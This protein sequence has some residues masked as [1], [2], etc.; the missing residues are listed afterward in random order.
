MLCSMAER[1]KFKK[2]NVL[3]KTNSEGQTCMLVCSENL[4][5]ALN[6]QA[7][8]PRLQLFTEPCIRWLWPVLFGEPCVVSLP[9]RTASGSSDAAGS[10]T[11]WNR[12]AV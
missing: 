9:L 6:E 10:L 4:D 11:L 1:L 12:V 3:K 7:A 8:Q 2:E 5:T